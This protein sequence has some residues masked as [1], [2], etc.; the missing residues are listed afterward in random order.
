MRGKNVWLE[1]I[2]AGVYMRKAEIREIAEDYLLE[3]GLKKWKLTKV[4]LGIP[5]YLLQRLKRDYPDM[6]GGFYGCTAVTGPYE[7]ILAIEKDLSANMVC[8]VVGHEITHILLAQLMDDIGF[9][10]IKQAQ[11]SIE[12]VCNRVG[13]VLARR[14]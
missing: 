14:K 7:F 13:N 11:K 4:H 9:G 12:T 1:F 5:N 8:K 2:T 6:K 10:R 3:L